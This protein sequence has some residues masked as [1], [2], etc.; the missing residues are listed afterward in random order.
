MSGE[1]DFKKELIPG[2]HQIH[3]IDA[4]DGIDTTSRYEELNFMVEISIREKIREPHKI[5]DG[6]VE[7]E[8]DNSDKYI[9]LSKDPYKYCVLYQKFVFSSLNDFFVNLLFFC[10][11]LNNA[12]DEILRK[13]LLLAKKIRQQGIQKTDIDLRV[14]NILNLPINKIDHSARLTI[15]KVMNIVNKDDYANST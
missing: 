2:G 10:I 13:N 4:S 5:L 15:A 9:L 3:V 8:V 11:A 14:R 6:I 7:I 1:G 12:S